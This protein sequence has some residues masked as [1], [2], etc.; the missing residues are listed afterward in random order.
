VPSDKKLKLSLVIPVYNE[1]NHLKACLDSIA[2]QTVLPDEVIVVDNN[3]SDKS[4]KIVKAYPFVKVVREKKQG[5]VHARNTGFN[6][7]AL[8][9]IGRIDA[10]TILPANWVHYVKDFFADKEHANHALTGGAYFYNIRTPRLNG[11]FQSQL[12]YRA[13]RLVSG[14]YILWGSNMALPRKLWKEVKVHTCTDKNIHEDMDLAIHWHRLG[15]QITY[16]QNL[17]VGVKL[18]RVFTQR[19]DLHAHMARWPRTLKQHGYKLWWMGTIGNLFLWYIAQP[20][21]FIM[22]GLSRIIG[23]RALSD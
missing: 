5:I 23:R 1:E 7:A 20:V 9:L 2:A 12:A 11:W 15:Y 4:M 16:R 18:K 6:A 3:S 19:S 8:D 13:N 10:D 14:H 17:K 21:I 22:E